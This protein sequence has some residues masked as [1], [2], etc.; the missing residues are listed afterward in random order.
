M[1]KKLFRNLSLVMMTGLLIV[2][3]SACGKS[4]DSNGTTA[5]TSDTAIPASEAFAEEGIW[6]YANE[7]V[8]KD[9]VI[10]AILVFDGNGNV[11]RYNTN[12]AWMENLKFGD[13]QDLSEDEILELAKEK[14]KES[15]EYEMQNIAD[16]G[17]NVIEEIE[18][19]IEYSTN[20]EFIAEKQESLNVNKLMR[21][22]VDPSEYKE[23]QANPFTLKI[24]TDGTGNRTANETIEYS[25]TEVYYC[26]EVDYTFNPELTMED[27]KERGEW[28]PYR[29]TKSTIT[30]YPSA[31]AMTVYDMQFISCGYLSQKIEGEHPGIILDT[32][33]TDGIEVD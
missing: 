2:S 14:D 26:G 8:T 33:N 30:L 20:P 23:P 21:S 12:C 22:K 13:L 19:S 6:F 7:P 10:D 29:E 25:Y 5:N 3:L 4:K 17:D 28:T 31:G 18:R 16:D 24:E 1:K 32:P 11:T 9:A 27:I 15:Y